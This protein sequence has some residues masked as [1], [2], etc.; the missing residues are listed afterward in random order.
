MAMYHSYTDLRRNIR[1]NISVNREDRIT[2]QRVGLLNDQNVYYGS[3]A[4]QIQSQDAYI[5]GGQIRNTDLSNCIIRG[6][7]GAT[8]NMSDVAVNLTRLQNA[9]K[10]LEARQYEVED[11]VSRC[12]RY[13]GKIAV[14][15]QISTF[16]EIFQLA[17]T[18]LSV[19]PLEKGQSFQLVAPA[20]LSVEEQELC[21]RDYLF[22]VND[23]NVLDVTSADVDILR[24]HQDASSQIAELEGRIDTLESLVEQLQLSVWS[25]IS[26]DEPADE[27]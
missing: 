21:D 10:S 4:G 14:S 9:Q 15:S 26:A 16:T 20:N 25:L 8:I 19:G 18:Q 6:S 11:D 13:M 12:F 3:F 27:P 7:D 17:D 5:D 24:I 2:N 1:E 23:V 22:V